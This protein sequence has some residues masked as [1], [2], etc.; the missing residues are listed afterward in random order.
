MQGLCNLDSSA[1]ECYKGSSTEVLA[2]LLLER[3]NIDTRTTRAAQLYSIHVEGHTR[4]RHSSIDRG[5]NGDA[6]NGTGSAALHWAW[7]WPH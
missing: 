4:T 1:E 3:A 6:T 2:K 5:A 7:E